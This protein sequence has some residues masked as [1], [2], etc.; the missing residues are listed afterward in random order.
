MW[1]HI[2]QFF[3]NVLTQIWNPPT[4]TAMVVA[5]GTWINN[6]RIKELHV[7][8]NSRMTGYLLEAK[9]GSL[10][11]GRAEGIAST[12]KGTQIK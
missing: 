8:V 9:S 5:A 3:H 2:A 4:V 10:A 1:Q 11:Q 7:L 6:Q 12:K